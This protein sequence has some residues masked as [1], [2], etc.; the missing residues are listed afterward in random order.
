MSDVECVS[1][2]DKEEGASLLFLF[3]SLCVPLGSLGLVGCSIF[4]ISGGFTNHSA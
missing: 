1:D 4:G 2:L 3:F